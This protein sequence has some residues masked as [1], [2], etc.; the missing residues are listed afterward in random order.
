MDTFTLKQNLYL[1]VKT[2]QHVKEN[3]CW[4]AY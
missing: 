3:N 4:C 1:H 2:D